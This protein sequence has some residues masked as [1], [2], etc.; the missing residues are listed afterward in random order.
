MFKKIPREAEMLRPAGKKNSL[1]ND[2]SNVIGGALLVWEAAFSCEKKVESV[3]PKR[4]KPMKR[5]RSERRNEANFAF[6]F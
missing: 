5:N 3:W 4:V 2:P 6:F 1:T